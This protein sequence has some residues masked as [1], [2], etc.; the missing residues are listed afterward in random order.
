MTDKLVIQSQVAQKM[1]ELLHEMT[2]EEAPKF[3][4]AFWEIIERQWAA[5]DRLRIDKI[6]RVMRCMVKEGFVWLKMN[7]WAKD[8]VLR[9]VR[10]L[11][12]GPLNPTSQAG[13]IGHMSDI[14]VEELQ[15]TLEA[16]VSS[17][18]DK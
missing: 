7:N 13:I 1:A 8:D 14:Y 10:I 3:I 18:T 9:Y 5:I 6:Y 11:S 17:Q 15:R 4:R 12:K 2:R 16:P